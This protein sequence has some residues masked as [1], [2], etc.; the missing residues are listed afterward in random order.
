MKIPL[1][2]AE[3]QS[4]TQ[5]KSSDKKYKTFDD[6]KS[7]EAL[8]MFVKANNNPE[9]SADGLELMQISAKRNVGTIITARNYV[10]LIQLKDK[11]NTRI[12][13]LPKIFNEEEENETHTK[14][15]FIRMLK[16]LLNINY[17]MSSQTGLDAKKTS[18]FE[19]FIRAFINEVNRLIKMGLKSAYIEKCENEKFLKGKLI[20][21]RQIQ[22]NSIH[23]ERFYIQYDV[24][25]LNRPENKLIKST[26]LFLKSITQDSKNKL[27]IN[28]LLSVLDD[29]DYSS[30]FDGDFV[31]SCINRNMKEYENTLKL[32]RVFLKKESFTSFAG[33]TVAFALLFPMEKVFETYVY[34]IL[35]R[36]SPPVYYINKQDQSKYLFDAPQKFRLRPDIVMRKNDEHILLLDTKW[37]LLNTIAKENYGISQADMYQMF[38]YAKRFECKNI[39]M[40]YPF[41]SE[42]IKN[43][44]PH[45]YR[46]DEDGDFIQ[47]HIKF[48]DL[49]SDEVA[50]TLAPISDLLS[51]LCAEAL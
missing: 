32:A 20:L 25:C 29:V 38:A 51:E 28:Y 4:I 37:K 26:L 12:E 16:A 33:D 30:D 21:N 18:I 34:S 49:G 24:F 46:I 23:K 22:N 14:E 36:T 13:I 45:L 50:E 15:I 40:V 17:K 27:D 5:K 19:V 10:G 7:F 41:Y 39:A 42:D 44:V 31:K 35:K 3:Y 1:V 11:H 6:P 47:I 48:I 43:V 9:G 8:E 2:I